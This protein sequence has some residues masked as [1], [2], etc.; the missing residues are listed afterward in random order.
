M[1]KEF[2][3]NNLSQTKTSGKILAQ[4]VLK[5]KPKKTAF[6][7]CLEGDLGGGKTTFL[8]AFGKGLGIKDRILSPTFVILR[9][10]QIPDSRF[11]NFYHIDC[12]RIEDQKEIL[13]LGFRGVVKNSEN[14]VAIEWADKIKEIIPTGAIWIK[15]EFIDKNKRKIIIRY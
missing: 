2:I 12:Y 8:Q 5:T 15:F 13:D 7:L 11:Q 1:K 6:L 9:R 4:E 14:I 3:T 10:F